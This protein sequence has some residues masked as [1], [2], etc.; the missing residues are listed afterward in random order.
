MGFNTYTKLLIFQ[1]LVSEPLNSC[2]ENITEEDV[3]KVSNYLLM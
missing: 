2:N 3:T 1:I